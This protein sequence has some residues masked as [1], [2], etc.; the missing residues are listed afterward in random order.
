VTERRTTRCVVASDGR[1][2]FSPGQ[3]VGRRLTMMRFTSGVFAVRLSCLAQPAVIKSVQ[4]KTSVEKWRQRATRGKGVLAESVLAIEITSCELRC[5][6]ATS[7][8][9]RVPSGRGPTGTV[10]GGCNKAERQPPSRRFSFTLSRLMMRAPGGLCWARL[11]N[12][13]W[14]SQFCCLEAAGSDD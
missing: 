4:H 3:R 11:E 1:R 12:I 6:W 14:Y 2:T 7:N 9:T 10:W 13:L 8:S 5:T